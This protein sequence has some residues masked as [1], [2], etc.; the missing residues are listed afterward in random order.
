M[1]KVKGYSYYN[2]LYSRSREYRLHYKDSCYYVLWTQVLQF[3]K[4]TENP[5][6]LEIE[7]GAGQFT[8][9][10]YDEGYREYHG[11]D[12]SPKATKMAKRTV[13]QSFSKGDAMDANAYDCDYGLVVALEVMEHVKDDL[14]VIENIKEGTPIVFSLPTF[15]DP[16]HARWFINPR[17]I[18]KRYYK[19]IDIKQIIRIDNWF[20]CFGVIQSFDPGFLNRTFQTREDVTLRY[21]AKTLRRRIK[22][23]L[24]S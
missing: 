1:G 14:A 15:D 20:A 23:F 8:H 16:A 7:C 12:F 3:I 13:N 19:Y 9:Y 17:Q 10:L 2:E 5:K 24:V 6:I 4:L 11:F 18:I 22:R 21:I